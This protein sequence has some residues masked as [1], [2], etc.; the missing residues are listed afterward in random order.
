MDT[1]IM[2]TN[3][4]KIDLNWNSNIEHKNKTKS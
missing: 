2:K 1:K 3:D 4:K